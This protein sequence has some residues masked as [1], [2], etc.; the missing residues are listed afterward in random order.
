MFSRVCVALDCS[1]Q[2]ARALATGIELALKHNSALSTITIRE[3]LPAYISFAVFAGADAIGIIEQ[4]RENLY[5]SLTE[6]AVKQGEERGVCVK[7]FLLD[8]NVV[9]SIVNFVS[10]QRLICSS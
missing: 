1:Q 9:D 6:Y 7:A 5:R 10:R 3:R 2:S 8:G 4:D